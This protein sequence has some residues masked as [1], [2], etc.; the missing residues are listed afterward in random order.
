MQLFVG[1][2]PHKF[3]KQELCRVVA[4][5]TRKNV[6]LGLLQKNK[7]T[8]GCKIMMMR[9]KDHGESQYFAIISNLPYKIAQRVIKNLDGKC[10]NG[11]ILTVREYK[12]RSWKNDARQSQSDTSSQTGLE[13]RIGE[14]R[15]HWSITEV[16][17]SRQ[18]VI[19]G[20]GQFVK[21]Y[22]R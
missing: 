2:F 10:L 7:T 6:L 17:D 12:V 21:M 3:S 1:R 14:R 19:E 18:I 4:R 5:A 20:L 9:N 11:C 15:N 16:K 13:R 22:D 8:F